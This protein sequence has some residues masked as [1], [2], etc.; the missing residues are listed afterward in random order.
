MTN[1]ELAEAV[2]LPASPCLTR[3]KGLEKAG[4]IAGYGTQIQIEK[5]GDVPIVFTEVTLADHRREDLRNSKRQSAPSTKSSNAISRAAAMTICSSSSR[6][7]CTITR[8]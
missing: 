7:A 3:V 5:L 8:A 2:G 1:V 6:A 4:Y